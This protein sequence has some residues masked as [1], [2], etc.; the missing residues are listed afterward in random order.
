MTAEEYSGHYLPVV[1]GGLRRP[2]PAVLCWGLEGRVRR[3]ILVYCTCTVPCTG[4]LPGGEGEES[5]PSRSVEAEEGREGAVT[6]RGG[7]G[8][9]LGAG[10]R[11]HGSLGEERFSDF[12]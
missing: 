7:C 3:A 12:R 4:T 10:L 8:E 1:P 2:R 5:S 9:A 6:G 11:E